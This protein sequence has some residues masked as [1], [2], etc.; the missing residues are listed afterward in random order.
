M[1]SVLALLVVTAILGR[2]GEA[3]DCLER[4]LTRWAEQLKTKKKEQYL[5]MAD[6][7][8]EVDSALKACSFAGCNN[9]STEG[10]LKCLDNAV[11]MMEKEKAFAICEK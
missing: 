9:D 8:V 2:I 11:I 5:Q 3:N 7:K 6:C 1:R 4:T 10:F